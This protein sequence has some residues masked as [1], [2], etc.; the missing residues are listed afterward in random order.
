MTLQDR[1]GFQ[2]PGGPKSAQ[3]HNLQNRRQ[4]GKENGGE[5]RGADISFVK[6]DDWSSTEGEEEEAPR[7]PPLINR[8]LK[9]LPVSNHI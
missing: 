2:D 6:P 3:K 7:D 8:Y 5:S 9:S 4:E 1:K